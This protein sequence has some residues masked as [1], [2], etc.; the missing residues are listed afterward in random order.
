MTPRRPSTII[1]SGTLAAALAAAPLAAQTMSSRAGA[2]GNGPLSPPAT[3]TKAANDY[4]AA[5]VQPAYDAYRQAPDSL[6][7]DRLKAYSAAYTAAAAETKQ[8]A[9][10]C[11]AKFAVATIPA[12]QLFDLISLYQVAGDTTAARQATDRLLSEKTLPPR[13]RGQAL[14][15]GMSREA[16]RDPSFFGIIPAAEHFVDEID[17]LPDSLNDVK[18]QAHRTMLGRYEYLDVADGLFHHASAVITLG[19]E[20]K[21]PASMI[22]GYLSLARSFA[23]RL[24]SDSALKI[25][26]AG[27]REIGPSA[28]EAF[29]DFRDRYALIGT[30]APSIE[31]QWW[32][33]PDR[34]QFAAPAPGKVTLIEF[35]AHWCGPCKNSYPGLRELAQRLKGEPFTGFMVTQLY[36]YIGTRQHLTADEEVAADREYFGT[37]HALPFPVAINPQAHPVPGQ[38]YPRPK[39]DADYRVG[40]IP[41]I[42]IIDKK[43]IIRE[44][45]TGWDHG[46]T[47]RFQQLIEQLIRESD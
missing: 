28:T 22:S 36:G 46:N 16:T 47:E 8:M 42:M 43:G 39:A 7:A 41:Q 34:S 25:L 33:N 3:C 11:A 30:R 9:A 2:T 18:L 35:T 23:D 10:E 45:V 27:E 37:E 4:R 24:N 12:E 20:L 29:K 15:L 14:L 31:A 44:I 21:Q 17:A 5:K 13:S 6:R 32:I 40:G 38:P 19:R 26:D 1:I